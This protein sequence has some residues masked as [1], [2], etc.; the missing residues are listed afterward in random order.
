MV[1]NVKSPIC[2][3]NIV[4]SVG[5]RISKFDVNGFIKC[6]GVAQHSIHYESPTRGPPKCIERLEA[7]LLKYV[8]ALKIVK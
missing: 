4:L 5:E 2:S 3:V 8:Y 1:Y 6:L 7:T